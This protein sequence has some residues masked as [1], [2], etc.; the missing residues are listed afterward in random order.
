MPGASSPSR[1][2]SNIAT[3]PAFRSTSVPCRCVDTA[4]VR[5]PRLRLSLMSVTVEPNGLT[6]CRWT[7]ARKNSSCRIVRARRSSSDRLM[8]REARKSRAP[9]SLGLP[10]VNLR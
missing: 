4:A 10:W 5:M 6:P 8:S 3:T 2:M 1:T 7:S 9:A